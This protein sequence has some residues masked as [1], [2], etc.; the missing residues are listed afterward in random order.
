MCKYGKWS[1][2][3]PSEGLIAIPHE[4]IFAKKQKSACISI[5]SDQ[6]LYYQRLNLMNLYREQQGL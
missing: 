5:P 4:N 3:Y 6:T 1:L 2:N